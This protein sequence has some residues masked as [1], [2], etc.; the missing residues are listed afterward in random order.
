MEPIYQ[1]NCDSNIFIHCVCV[2]VCVYVLCIMYVCVMY[3]QYMCVCCG[4][5][6]KTEPTERFMAVHKLQFT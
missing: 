2:C 6:T 5:N 4:V 1:Q 3:D